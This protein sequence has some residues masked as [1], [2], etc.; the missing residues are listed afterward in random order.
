MDN[1]FFCNCTR[2]YTKERFESLFGR[3]VQVKLLAS[4]LNGDNICKQA[5]TI[6]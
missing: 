4:I 5:I 1:P 6:K 3:P 2:G